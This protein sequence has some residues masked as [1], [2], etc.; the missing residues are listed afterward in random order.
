MQ[1]KLYRC[2]VFERQIFS[3]GLTNGFLCDRLVLITQ[4]GALHSMINLLYDL[5]FFVLIL[6]LLFALGVCIW[7]ITKLNTPEK[8][9]WRWMLYI[10]VLGIPLL[11]LNRCA[12][13][14]SLLY[15]YKQIVSGISIAYGF[16]FFIGLIAVS[17]YTYKK[18]FIS[19]K[20]NSLL[21]IALPL[22]ILP[23]IFFLIIFLL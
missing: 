16:L 1:I 8:K 10:T 2:F 9:P 18:G 15:P 20:D 4:I 13:D 23:L 14:F 19:N 7:E 12:H 5:P 21:F 22:I 6:V 3:Y 11:L 17:I